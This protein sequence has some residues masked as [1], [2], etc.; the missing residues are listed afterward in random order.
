MTWLS[1][2][3]PADKHCFFGSQGGFSN[4]KYAS[5]NINSASLDNPELIQKNYALIASRF[6]L[7]FENILRLIQGISA[8]VVLV[9]RP[10]FRQLT[11]DG[12]VTTTKDIILSISTA[13]CAPVLLADYHNG[14]IGAAH[15]GWRSAYKGIIENTVQLMLKQGANIKHISAAIG[16]CIQQ[17][18]F[19]V[20]AEVH[21]MFLEQSVNNQAYFISSPKPNYYFLDLS[22]YIADKLS[23]LGITS[24]SNSGIDTYTEKDAYFSYR[25][26]THLGLISAPKD[27]PLEL[28]TITL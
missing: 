20:G 24:I 12:V 3:L 28:S 9:D 1:P 15:G 2:N 13:D 5:L 19:E 16:P 10:S 8:D 17:P 18:S 4:G 14:V 6:G 11:A 27:F 21:A 23:R 26:D 7:Q 25:R 22:S